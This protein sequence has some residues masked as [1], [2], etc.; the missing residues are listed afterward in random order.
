MQI[1]VHWSAEVSRSFPEIYLVAGIIR[2]VQIER[3]NLKISELKRTA[4]E[5]A[6]AKHEIEALKDNPVIRAYRDFY[7]KLDIDPTKI[8]PSGEA[9]LRRVLRGNELPT[10][11]TAADAYNLASMKTM[12]PISGFDL[13]RINPPL[14]VRFAQNGE[15]FLGIGMDKPVVLNHKMLVLAD[16]TG[17]VCIYPYRDSD[18]TKI[19]ENTRNILI[20]GYGAP[21]IERQN[22]VESV[23]MALTYIKTVSGGK[24]DMIK[25]FSP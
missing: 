9:L 4:Y 12:I 14:K 16:M 13:D 24:W 18:Y 17:I 8:R 20:V 5:E 2:G 25:V 11:N 7:W 3:E 15:T 22:V 21:G 1:T 10:I 6:R 23:E 19:T